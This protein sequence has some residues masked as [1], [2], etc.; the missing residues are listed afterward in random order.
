MTPLAYT[1]QSTGSH[2]QEVAMNARA[3]KEL[4]STQAGRRLTT[5]MNDL[6]QSKLQTAADLL[7]ATLNQFVLQA[8]VE[9]ADK[10]IENESSI[11]L[12]RRESARLLAMIDNPPPMNKKL[13]ALMKEYE[14]R[15]VNGSNSSFKW[16]T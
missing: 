16:P 6:V 9:K 7:G 8:A 3:E 15:K 12:T 13:K 11:T 4:T 14:G 1:N 10:V 5:R 2:K